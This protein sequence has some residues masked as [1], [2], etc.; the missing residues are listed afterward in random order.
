MRFQKRETWRFPGW[1]QTYIGLPIP[2][3][4]PLEPGQARATAYRASTMASGVRGRVFYDNFSCQWRGAASLDADAPV[5]WWGWR[6]APA[7]RRERG[8]VG[9]QDDGSTTTDKEAPVSPVSLTGRWQFRDTGKEV[10]VLQAI[11]RFIFPC[12]GKFR[13]TCFGSRTGCNGNSSD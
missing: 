11:A 12:G 1:K 7:P 3:I 8:A 13:I 4:N 2:V 6:G 10:L 9:V 5:Q